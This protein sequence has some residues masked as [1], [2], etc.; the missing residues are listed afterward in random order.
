MS[1]IGS[2]HEYHCTPSSV[3]C[4]FVVFRS[5]SFSQWLLLPSTFTVAFVTVLL[6][7]NRWFIISTPAI[8]IRIVE[9]IA[10]PCRPVFVDLDAH[11]AHLHRLFNPARF[12]EHELFVTHF[13]RAAAGRFR[14]CAL[15][16]SP[17]PVQSPMAA[18]IRHYRSRNYSVG[19]LTAVD[20]NVTGDVV[21]WSPLGNVLVQLSNLGTVSNLRRLLCAADLINVGPTSMLGDVIAAD[22]VAMGCRARVVH[23]REK[24]LEQAPLMRA[25]LHPPSIDDRLVRVGMC[26]T[27]SDSE[28]PYLMEWMTYYFGIG[29][30]LMVLID[31]AREGTAPLA[32]RVPELHACF[33]GSVL[34]VREAR[35][36]QQVP[37]YSKC[38]AAFAALSGEETWWMATFDADEFLVLPSNATIAGVVADVVAR[39]PSRNVGAVVFNWVYMGSD[40]HGIDALDAP[41][42]YRFQAR[43]R[44]ANFWVK[45]IVRAP[46]VVRYL[47][48]HHARLRDGFVAL[49]PGGRVVNGWQNRNPDSKSTSWAW[50]AHYHTKSW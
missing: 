18:A 40:D 21:P 29:V 31:N 48:A 24:N 16:W 4:T 35:R 15:V 27:L 12:G 13:G 33:G 23:L 47:S 3:P 10:L 14:V 34:I 46:S 30:E 45:S 42:T 49:D 11:P 28:D 41:L 6:S 17:R 50:L 19:L 9:S 38:A 1:V 22:L 44:K 2:P 8:D 20:S 39:N 26:A 43:K 5:G 25:R 36:Y 32:Q 7:S 37:S